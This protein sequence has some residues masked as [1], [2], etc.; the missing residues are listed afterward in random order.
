MLKHLALI[1]CMLGL[2][3]FFAATLS[4]APANPKVLMKTSKGD[5]TIELFQ[6][7]A[8][9]S[10]KN[11]LAYVDAKHYDNLIFHRVIKDFMIQGGGYD[12]EFHQ[13]ATRPPIKNEAANGLKNKRG[14]LAMART[15]EID[16]A[17]CQFFIN[18]VDNANLDHTAESFGYAVFGAVVAGMETVD[19]IA[20][21]P[22][23]TKRGM[24]DAPREDVIII[25]VTRVGD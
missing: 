16:S 9:L 15:N 13:K 4:A 6:D 21:T 25:S 24:R 20:S 1:S 23:M 11:F 22:T 7:K 2:T 14:T 18:T 3:A 10:V 5:I 19:A 12:V 8:P 17:T